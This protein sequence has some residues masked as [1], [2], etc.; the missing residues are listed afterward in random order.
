M[1]ENQLRTGRQ[2]WRKDCREDADAED[3]DARRKYEGS[4]LDT[5]TFPLFLS[6]NPSPGEL[7]YKHTT[8]SIC[9]GTHAVK[10]TVPIANTCACSCLHAHRMA[11]QACFVVSSTDPATHGGVTCGSSTCLKQTNGTWRERFNKHS[12]TFTFLGFVAV[13]FINGP[14][15][16]PI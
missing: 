9:R 13:R 15:V 12:V 7:S 4:S 3:S 11:G 14:A 16:E 6:H 5:S 1:R 2:W 8:L 10:Q